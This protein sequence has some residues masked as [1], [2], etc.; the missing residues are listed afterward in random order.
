LLLGPEIQQLGPL[1]DEVVFV[2][3]ASRRPLGE[4]T[5]A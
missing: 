3:A 4:H 5:T 2:G 1:V